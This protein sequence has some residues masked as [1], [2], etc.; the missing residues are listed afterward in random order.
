MAGVS[1][2]A[3]QHHFPTKDDM[4]VGAFERVVS[5]TEL[6]LS[7]LRLGGNVRSNLTQVLRELLPLDAVRLTEAR[8]YVAFAARA[9]TAPRLADVQ[10]ALQKRLIDGLAKALREAQAQGIGADQSPPLNPRADAQLLLAV[11]DGLTFDAVSNPASLT[12]RRATRLLDLYLQRL[13]PD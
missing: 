9:A 8:V 3:V 6:R 4:L 2:G 12:P 11:A 13:I 5:S 7:Q 1:I 10:Q